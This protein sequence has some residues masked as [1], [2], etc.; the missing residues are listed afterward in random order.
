MA[1]RRRARPARQRVP[2]RRQAL[3]QNGVGLQTSSRSTTQLADLGW[4]VQ[5]WVDARDLPD[6]QAN[7]RAFRCRSWLITWAGL[8]IITAPKI[9]ASRLCCG[10]SVK[11]KCGQRCRGLIASARR[12][13]TIRGQTV[14]RRFGRGQCRK[15]GLGHRL[16]ASTPGRPGAGRM[17]LREILLEWTTPA[18]QQAILVDNPARLYDFAPL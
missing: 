5:L 3:L 6:M 14:S 13:P 15:S 17:R 12:R 18:Q 8:S 10:A 2:A 1:R 11:E 4:H 7:W 9:P 16:A